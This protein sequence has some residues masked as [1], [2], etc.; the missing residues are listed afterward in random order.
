MKLYLH[1]KSKRLPVQKLTQG[2]AGMTVREQILNFLADVSWVSLPD[3]EAKFM[4]WN[5]DDNT[6][7]PNPDFWIALQRL[8]N[9]GI[10]IIKSHQEWKGKSYILTTLVGVVRKTT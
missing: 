10:V 1:E 9:E 7:E 4:I 5:A 2:S 3:L 6:Y 8:R